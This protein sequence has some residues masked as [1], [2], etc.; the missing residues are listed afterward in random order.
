M[1]QITTEQTKQKE[2]R[3]ELPPNPH[4]W[5]MFI[6]SLRFYTKI[7]NSYY[8]FSDDDILTSLTP[9]SLELLNPDLKWTLTEEQQYMADN[10]S[11]HN[12]GII[13]MWTG[14]WKSRVIYDT[15]CKKNCSTLILCHNIKTSVDM[16]NGILKNT[17]IDA[18]NVGLIC[19]T[20]KHPQTFKVD[21]CTH[22][23]F[24]KNYKDY[25]WK[26]ECI[27]YDE[28]D[29]NLSFPKW[30][31]YDCMVSALIQLDPIYL[32]WFT[33]TAF[34]A[35]W[36]VEALTKIYKNIFLFPNQDPNVSNNKYNIIPEISHCVYQY[37]WD[38][39]FENR[40]QLLKNLYLDEDRQ[41]FQIKFI[42][43]HK[44]KWN[45][46][47]VKSVEESEILYKLLSANNENVVLLNWTV[48]EKP[49]YDLINLYIKNQNGFMI[50]WTIDK[51]WRGVDIPPTDTL[52][53]Y[54]PIKFQWTVVQA[55]GR[56]LRK[57]PG[58]TNVLVYDWC[59]LPILVKQMRERDTSYKQEYWIEYVSKIN[60]L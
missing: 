1:K 41:Q 47:L 30:Q 56:A 23:S 11:K 25:I 17:N 46:V 18:E 21:V 16:Y 28:C 53:L 12:K 3:I 38:Y 14:R 35:E 34:R 6:R 45:M 44:R 10:I 24:V 31:N 55:V 36:G 7:W 2:Y 32:Y 26:Y 48:D 42:N 60:V 4:T 22:S 54:S 20:S 43:S 15:V 5:S 37:H 33:W 39:C 19:S 59:D 40:P 8:T 13:N 52:F 51:L 57:F 27:L 49:A 50:I 9:T 29:Y 58:K